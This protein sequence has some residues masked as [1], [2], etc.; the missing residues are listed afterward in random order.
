VDHLQEIEVMR[1]P[2]SDRPRRGSRPVWGLADEKSAFLD[3]GR[4]WTS[5]VGSCA[6]AAP[7]FSWV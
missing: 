4:R 7:L 3:A 1:M 2:I 5:G 6:G